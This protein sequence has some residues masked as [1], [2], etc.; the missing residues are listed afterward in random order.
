[1]AVIALS[2]FFVVPLQ[3]S[4]TVQSMPVGDK[5]MIWEQHDGGSDGR[6]TSVEDPTTAYNDSIDHNQSDD[7]SRHSKKL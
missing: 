2:R 6:A 1:M 7:S 3:D 5:S 4:H